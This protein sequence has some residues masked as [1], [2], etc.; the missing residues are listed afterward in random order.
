MSSNR[1]SSSKGL[2]RFRSSILCLSHSL[3]L[4][5]SERF[6]AC[7][8]FTG[9]RPGVR[10]CLVN[11]TDFRGVEMVE[12][13]IK[14]EH[15]LERLAF[16]DPRV[17]Y[18]N[19]MLCKLLFSHCHTTGANSGVDARKQHGMRDLT[20]DMTLLIFDELDGPG[21]IVLIQRGTLR[22]HD[23]EVG[24]RHGVRGTQ[25]GNAFRIDNHKR[26]LPFRVLDQV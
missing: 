13:C 19:A 20:A 6:Q 5:L 22:R 25:I 3:L 10:L 15:R 14:A 26:S 17:E 11:S 4:R 2:W 21:G 12:R 18:I 1:S 23:H 7:D 9:K 24:C 16:D 8:E